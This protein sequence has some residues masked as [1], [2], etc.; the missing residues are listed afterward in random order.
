MNLINLKTKL[1]TEEKVLR[2]E[3]GE[4]GVNDKDNPSNWDITPSDRKQEIEFRDEMADRMED[5]EEHVAL[6]TTLKSRLQEVRHALEKIA[7]GKYGLCEI[8]G[9]AIEEERLNANPAARTTIKNM[10]QEANL[11]P[12][13]L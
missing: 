12:I 7:D 5:S 6:K 11:P 13:N 2:Q 8:S 9:E 10:S 4:I 1:E 3:L